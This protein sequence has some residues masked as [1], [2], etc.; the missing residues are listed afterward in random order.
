MAGRTDVSFMD[1]L[2]DRDDPV[3]KFIDDK[4]MFKGDTEPSNDKVPV[5]IY[6]PIIQFLN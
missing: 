4:E 2:F 1:I 6:H 5:F 3:L